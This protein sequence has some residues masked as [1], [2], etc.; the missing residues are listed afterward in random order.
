LGIAFQIQDDILGVFGSEKKMGKSA[1]SD[2]SEGKQTILVAKTLQKGNNQQKKRLL[3]ILGQKDL[4]DKEIKDF[5]AI[6]RET[7]ALQ[8][9]KDL[10]HRLIL[11]SKAALELAEMTKGSKKFLLDLA[12][13]MEK[14]EV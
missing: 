3:Q 6:I 11:Q 5:R 12:E 2:I 9:A 10:A 4:S 8:Y 14:R 1:A 13:V 7:G